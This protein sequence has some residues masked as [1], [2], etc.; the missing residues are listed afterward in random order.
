MPAIQRQV[1]QTQQSNQQKFYVTK[2]AAPSSNIVKVQQT[3]PKI[4]IQSAP[5]SVYVT[6][7]SVQEEH[8]LDDLS[9]LE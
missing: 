5:K 6:T 8:E 4:Y 2:S 1:S 7:S 3:N 9:H